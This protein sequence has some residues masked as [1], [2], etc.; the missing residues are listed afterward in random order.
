MTKQEENG[1]WALFCFIFLIPF[2]FWSSFVA[3]KIWLWFAPPN[4]PEMKLSS[5]ILIACLIALCKKSN[6]KY[7]NED[8]FRNLFFGAIISPAIVLFTAWIAKILIGE[9][10]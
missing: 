2:L 4:W 10:L 7:E 8:Y 1:I 6:Y 9:N 5:F 3:S